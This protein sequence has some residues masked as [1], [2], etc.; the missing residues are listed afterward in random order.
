MNIKIFPGTIKYNQVVNMPAAKSNLHRA[1]ICASLAEGTSR[2]VGI[3]YC[4]D[5][6]ATIEACRKIGAIINSEDNCLVIQ[7]TN[8]QLNIHDT[9]IDCNESGTTLRLMM[10]LFAKS[11]KNST[12]LG[13]ENLLNRPLD[14]Y[15]RIFENN[16]GMLKHNGDYINVLGGIKSGDYILDGSQ[17]SQFTSGMLIVLP[18]CEGNSSIVLGDGFQSRDYVDLTIAI[19]KKFNVK[20]IWESESKILIK[21]NQKYK[22]CDM[23]IEGDFSQFSY[24]AALG[25]LNNG[26]TCRNLNKNSLQGDKRIIEF[27]KQMGVNIVE[28]NDGYQI[29]KSVINSCRFDIQDCIDLG[30]TL[31]MMG[32]FCDGVFYI[33][34]SKRLVFKESNRLANI[35]NELK[36]AGVDIT[37]DENSISVI[38]KKSYSCDCDLDSC[39]DHRIFMSLAILATL[40]DK[41]VVIK[42][43]ESINKSFPLFIDILESLGIHIEKHY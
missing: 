33:D 37:N 1:I 10:P 35:V 30:P 41:P 43:A 40:N 18:L 5:I 39:N 6:T 13:K 38:G 3:N 27:L 36:K 8:N 7:G 32:A 4:D 9:T 2:I 24:F 21:G 12:F 28:I 34:N 17:S 42:K 16:G 25:A 31:A 26:I 29:G 11:N 22:A 23:Q 20:F 15:I 14:E 19:L